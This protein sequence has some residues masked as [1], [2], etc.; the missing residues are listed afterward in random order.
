MNF[1]K[2]IKNARTTS[3]IVEE[4]IRNFEKPDDETT[5]QRGEAI[6]TCTL[7][8]KVD[9]AALTTYEAQKTDKRQTQLDY[10]LS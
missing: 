10:F 9:V 2:P 5:E 8:K 4:E 7:T 6:P 3:A 1:K